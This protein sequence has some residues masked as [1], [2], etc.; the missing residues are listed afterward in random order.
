V[1]D[2]FAKNGM[3]ANPTHS[4]AEARAWLAGDMAHWRKIIAEAKIDLEGN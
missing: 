4:P 3:H 2:I 1:K